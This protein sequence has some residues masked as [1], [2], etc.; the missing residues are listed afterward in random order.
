MPPRR[1]TLLLAAATLAAVV[2]LL[3]LNAQRAADDLRDA[4]AAVGDL[5]DALRENDADARDGA[6]D[7][8]Q[9][10]AGSAHDR[11]SG[12]RWAPL[13]HVPFLGDDARAVQGVATSLDLLARRA[14]PALL[15][16]VERADGLL[17]GGGVD[18]AVL[19][20]ISGTVDHAA[21]AL[22]AAS[23]PVAPIDAGGLMDRVRRPYQ[24]YV[25]QLAD[26]DALVDR[27]RDVLATLPGALGETRP[28][29]YLVVLQNNAEARATGG[30]PQAWA[31]LQSD[32]GQWDVTA[33]GTDADY[34]TRTRPVLRLTPAERALYGPSLARDVLDATMTPD[35]PRM[36]E[37]LRAQW[38]AAGAPVP[39]DGVI[40][41][42]TVAL[43]YLLRG[44]P[45]VTVTP[46]VT[47]TGANAAQELL[48]GAAYQQS[49]A[50][51][52]AFLQRAAVAVLEQ[53]VQHAGAGD[54]LDALV[55][56]AAQG[57]A[58][59]VPFADGARRALEGTGLLGGTAEVGDLPRVD[60]T[61]DAETDS[62]SSFGLRWES[63]VTTVA[64]GEL[65]DLEAT[66]TV[67]RRPVPGEPDPDALLPL[68]VRVFG[69]PG[70]R[71]DAV[72]VDGAPVETD[73]ID[74]G[75]R[76]AVR[77]GVAAGATATTVA[78][79]LSAPSDDAR[80][81]AVH[82]TPGVVPVTGVRRVPVVCP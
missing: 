5:R 14:G 67:L 52:A 38:D 4:Q 31:L 77:V 60:L 40:T 29:H 66:L 35:V 82:T 64:C 50:E 37:I 80:E 6:L 1:R 36:A 73:V 25:D 11:T 41:L 48:L 13:T 18:L 10:A 53:L 59:V 24:D 15:D 55:D 44:L 23:A 74:V 12:L 49:P 54:T 20:E 30:T 78:V 62:P 39:L 51:R 33:H 8:L 9:G 57:R 58:H 69:P 70:S 26:L 3:G 7:R 17:A 22:T 79:R 68:T 56:G 71:I 65:T 19:E 81:L 21:T 47:L 2:I 34:P 63:A 61:V 46:D 42:D 27:A 16:A 32:E 45:P 76:P 75:G 43:G 28:Q 72:R